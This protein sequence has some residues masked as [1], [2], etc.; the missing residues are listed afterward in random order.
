[1]TEQLRTRIVL[2]PTGKFAY[3]SSEAAQEALERWGHPNLVHR[4]PK[5]PVRHYR[6]LQCHLWHLTAAKTYGEVLEDISW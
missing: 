2:C 1:M 6:C 4:E 5:R 3:G